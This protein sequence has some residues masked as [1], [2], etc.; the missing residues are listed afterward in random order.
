MAG[1]KPTAAMVLSV[2]GGLFILF[3]GIALLAIADFLAFILL[4]GGESVG[5]EAVL[6]VQILGAIG[7]VIGLVIIVGGVLMYARPASSTAWGVIILVISLV[8]IIA[9]G[10]FIL[11]LILGLIGGILGIV[12]KPT[13]PMAPV[14]A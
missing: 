4:F 13:A 12:F 14:A 10:G 3:G 9:T 1:E 5:I 11:G 2:I 7:I 6:F 8:S